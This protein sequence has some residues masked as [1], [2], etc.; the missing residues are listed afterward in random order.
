MS[1]TSHDTEPCYIAEHSTSIEVRQ[2][3]DHWFLSSVP[4]GSGQW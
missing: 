3:Q 4:V 1:R 2:L